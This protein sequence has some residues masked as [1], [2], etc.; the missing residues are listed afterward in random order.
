[1]NSKI[2]WLKKPAHFG[3]VLLL[4]VILGIGVTVA[5]FT[6]IEA[7]VN[8]FKTGKVEIELNE[9]VSNLKKSNIEV[10]GLGTSDSYV[11][12]RADIPNVTYTYLDG[13]QNEREGQAL[14]YDVEANPISATEWASPA[15]WNPP[16]RLPAEIVRDHSAEAGY[17]WIKMD[18]GF[19]YLSTT[20]KK[21][22]I[23]RFLNEISFPGLWKDGTEG[24]KGT[25]VT[26]LPDGLTL[27]ML[28]IPIVAEAVQVEGIDVG[29]GVTGAKAAEKAFQIVNG[30]NGTP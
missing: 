14:I 18:D 23:A 22:E 8:Q 19:W 30:E 27:E 7:A 26:P 24:S 29:E 9:D 21:D 1:M 16:N 20:L 6:D 13:E 3:L 4:A 28:T 2:G 12:I 5:F 10:T 25:V 17:D 11:R 15:S